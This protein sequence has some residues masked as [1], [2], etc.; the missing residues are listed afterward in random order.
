MPR[1]ISDGDAETP[2]TVAPYSFLGK[3]FPK[4]MARHSICLITGH[5]ADLL[6]AGVELKCKDHSH[7]DLENAQLM[8]SG[9]KMRPWLDPD[10]DPKLKANL[11]TER[12]RPT[13]QWAVIPCA[14]CDAYGC[15]KCGGLGRTT[16]MKYLI[17]FSAREWQ[18][19]GGALQFLLPGSTK[20]QMKRGRTHLRQNRRPSRKIDVS[21]LSGKRFCRSVLQRRH[22][23]L[24]AQA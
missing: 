23:E 1:H 13:A 19:R 16:S 22:P 2:K 8:V 12:Y 15:Q 4:N 6:I 10:F 3:L 18:C 5:D 20:Q 24:E 7:I 9:T 17:R 11:V 14:E 21:V